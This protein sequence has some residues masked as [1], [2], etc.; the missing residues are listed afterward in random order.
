MARD[1]LWRTAPTAAALCAILVLFVGG[2]ITVAR[3]FAGPGQATETP[4]SR[5]APISTSANAEFLGFVRSRYP[6]LATASDGVLEA[7]GVEGCTIFGHGGELSDVYARIPGNSP[8]STLETAEL[9]A[10]GVQSY[11]PQYLDK[12]TP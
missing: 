11:C 2:A 3:V 9:V 10:V 5:P 4:T 12:L 6:E 7:T 8:F 1:R